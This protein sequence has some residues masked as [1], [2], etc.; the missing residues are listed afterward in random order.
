MSCLAQQNVEKSEE[1]WKWCMADSQFTAVL[2]QYNAQ[3]ASQLYNINDDIHWPAPSLPP[4]SFLVLHKKTFI[5]DTHF[6]TLVQSKKIHIVG[7][8]AEITKTGVKFLQQQQ[9]HKQ[10]PESSDMTRDFD[11]IVLC[12]GFRP[13]LEDFLVDA[14]QYLS[15]HR[16]AL[17]HT[18]TVFYH[19]HTQ[20]EVQVIVSNNMTCVTCRVTHTTS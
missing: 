5:D 13:A 9:Q 2:D 7:P 1:C 6:L 12:T 10:Q 17:P 14:E 4:A 19:I 18:T 16:F 8:V 11:G 3:F 15:T 20:Q